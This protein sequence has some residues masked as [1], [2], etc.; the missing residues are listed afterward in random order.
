KPGEYQVTVSATDLE[1][2]TG[3]AICKVIVKEAVTESYNPNSSEFKSAVASNM[4][5]LVNQ[6]RVA[7]GKPA[8]T[9]ESRLDGLANSWSKYMAD[10][11]FF[12]HVAPG[13]ETANSVF[14]SYGTTSAENIVLIQFKCTG[15]MGQD[16]QKL[17]N[18]LFSM[19]KNSSAHNASMLGDYNNLFGFGF[20]AVQVSE[21]S[22]NW[23]IYATQEF[24]YKWSPDAPKDDVKKE[25]APQV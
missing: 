16:A 22:P 1:R 4:V 12:D 5:A 9:H 24:D 21:G 17:A 2:A 13:G 8:A 20:H 10:N 14:P 11:N 6:H 3:S 18:Q 25:E 7:N 23:S 19:W 15:D